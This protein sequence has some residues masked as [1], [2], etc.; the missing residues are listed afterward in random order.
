MTF[1]LGLCAVTIVSALAVS[2]SLERSGLRAPDKPGAPDAGARE[3]SS[4]YAPTPS[5]DSENGAAESGGAPTGDNPGAAASNNA[6]PPSLSNAMLPLPSAARL[7]E[8]DEAYLDAFTILREDTSCSR[9]FGGS[10][11]TEPLNELK[12]RL[13]S[14]YLD[15]MIALKMSGKVLSA[16]NYSTKLS[17]RVF[18]E[19]EIN[20]NGPFYRLNL[21]G[22]LG[23]PNI[24]PFAPSTRE[25]RVTILL[26]EL[27]HMIAR[28][29]K[30][31]VLPDDGRDMSLSRENTQKVIEACRSQIDQVSHTKPAQELLSARAWS[32]SRSEQVEIAP[33]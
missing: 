11:A 17:Y 25:A 1:V 22:G 8:L 3:L 6:P 27:G 2:E 23:V 9:F 16:L 10:G 28:P 14:S 5:A 24:G 19:T 12:R 15:R 30:R 18:A 32:G 26:H 4:E 21:G 7:T 29:D 20:L 33:H 31:W 13:K